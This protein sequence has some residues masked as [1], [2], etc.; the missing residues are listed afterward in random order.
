MSDFNPVNAVL[1]AV[2]K[3][4]VT[5]VTAIWQE[6]ELGPKATKVTEP[7]LISLLRQ[8]IASSTSGSGGGGAL[9]NQRSVIDGDALDMYEKLSKDILNA[10]RGVTT[11]APF[12][13]PEK[14]LRQWFI[15]VSNEVR[16]GKLDE[17]T[18]LSDAQIWFDWIRIIEDKLFPPTTLEV[19]APC[20]VEGCG[21]RWAKSGSGDSIPAIVIQHRPPSSERV[22]ALAKSHAKC[23]ACG[24]VWRGDRKLRELAFD[25][26]RMNVIVDVRESSDGV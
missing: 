20:P 3:L 2:D 23:R 6:Y 18:L 21:K 24:T 26:D 19:V 17:G 9:P 4:T 12:Q 14:N 1:D 5:K 16:S 22:N 13:E 25:I 15:A 7:P 8:A 11:A 10:Y